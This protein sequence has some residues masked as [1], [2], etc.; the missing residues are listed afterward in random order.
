MILLSLILRFLALVFGSI[1]F[2]RAV[3]RHQVTETI[4]CL[5]LHL[6]LRSLRV[7]R[8]KLISIC[9]MSISDPALSQPS[10][11]FLE[12]EIFHFFDCE[13]ELEKLAF[14]LQLQIG[15]GL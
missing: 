14:V 4:F 6:L 2:I 3:S 13:F 7:L 1:I 15:S 12:L 5:L 11:F 9:H 10:L 8:I